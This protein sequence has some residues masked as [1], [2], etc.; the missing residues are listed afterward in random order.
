MTDRPWLM[1]GILH[2]DDG[3]VSWISDYWIIR[4]MD[5]KDDG[6]VAYPYK[7]RYTGQPLSNILGGSHNTY[8]LIIG[9]TSM[10]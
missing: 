3:T 4:M 6:K 8:E 9:L 7:L 5:D 2:P 10:E 1:Y